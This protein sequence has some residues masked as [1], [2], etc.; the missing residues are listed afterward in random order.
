MFQHSHNHKLANFVL[1]T[2]KSLPSLTFSI[3]MQKTI[4]TSHN[5]KLPIIM[6]STENYFI[7]CGVIINNYG[8]K[9]FE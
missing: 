5:F 2:L 9:L 8:N 3:F 1:S 7:N 4:K 6:E